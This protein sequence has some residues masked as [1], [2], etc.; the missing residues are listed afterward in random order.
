MKYVQINVDQKLKSIKIYTRSDSN[1]LG[2]NGDS[3]LL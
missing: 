2:G 1:C 3:H